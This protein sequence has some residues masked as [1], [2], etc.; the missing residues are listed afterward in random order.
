MTTGGFPLFPLNF[1]EDIEKRKNFYFLCN[2][3]DL[4]SI[5][6]H[7][8]SFL[9]YIK[10]GLPKSIY[11]IDFSNCEKKIKDNE[12]LNLS[13]ILSNIKKCSLT[14]Q[15]KLSFIKKVSIFEKLVDKSKNWSKYHNTYYEQIITIKELKDE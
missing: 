13:N 8:R 6:I 1:I 11:V 10:V 5:N 2:I 9:S 4:T 14:K 15:T 12:E 3:K 7:E